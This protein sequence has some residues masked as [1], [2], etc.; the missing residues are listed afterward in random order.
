MVHAPTRIES[1]VKPA[2]LEGETMSTSLY[3]TGKSIQMFTE[4]QYENQCKLEIAVLKAAGL[5]MPTQEEAIARG[6]FLPEGVHALAH[7]GDGV[8]RDAKTGDLVFGCELLDSTRIR[9]LFVGILASDGSINPWAPQG[10]PLHFPSIV[11]E[12]LLKRTVTK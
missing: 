5:P 1:T 8:P 10:S 2:S 7:V 3:S 4:R 11:A 12:F 6:T 9:I